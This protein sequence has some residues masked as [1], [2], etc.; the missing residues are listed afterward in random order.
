MVVLT[1]NVQALQDPVAMAAL[2]GI[3]GTGFKYV[4]HQAGS[5]VAS[6]LVQAKRV[7]QES[8][9]PEY[10]NKGLEGSSPDPW[11]VALD[12]IGSM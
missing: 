12:N 4:G 2:Q 6:D 9:T 10:H 1:D 8:V 7:I 3:F 5:R 11:Q